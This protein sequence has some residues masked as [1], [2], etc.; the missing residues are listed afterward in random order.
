MP[1]KDPKKRNEVKRKWKKN[2]PL[3]NKEINRAY[4]EKNKERIKIYNKLYR[5]K[6]QKR[7]SEKQK[8]DRRANP[9]KGSIYR[10]LKRETNIQYKLK[11]LLRHRVYLA[12][13]NNQKRGSAVR[14]LGCTIPELKT[15]LEGQFKEG[16]TWNNWTY[17]GWHIDHRVPLSSFDLTKRE[18]FLKAIHYT[19]LQPLWMHENFMKNRK[20]YGK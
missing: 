7:I 18:E 19:N 14:D 13:K 12:I 15:Y 8:R 16:M 2:H 6:N 17:T 9:E 10:K 3:Q 20:I 1:H 5:E 11:G 4:R